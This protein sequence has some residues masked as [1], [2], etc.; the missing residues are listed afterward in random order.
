M[1]NLQIFKWPFFIGLL[2]SI[3]LVAGLVSEGWGDV[4]ATIGL[5]CPI[6]VVWWSLL[7]R[8]D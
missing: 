3:G 7:I 4:L 1:T 5:S 8:R 2:T 6:G